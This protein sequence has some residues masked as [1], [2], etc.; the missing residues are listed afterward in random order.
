[1]YCFLRRGGFPSDTWEGKSSER[2]GV[3]Y[4]VCI[5]MQAVAAPSKA[6]LALAQ[7][8]W[9]RRLYLVDV[10]HSVLDVTG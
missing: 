1:M 4:Q 9:C 6:N 5:V 3:R 8:V 7:R 10:V 2:R